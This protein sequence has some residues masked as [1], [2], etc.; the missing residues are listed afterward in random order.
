MKKLFYILCILSGLVFLP[1]T[2]SAQCQKGEM[3]LG[4]A[5]G[6]AS[7][8]KSGYT[9]IYFQYAFSKHVRISPEIGYIFKN[10]GTSGL[11]VSVDMHFP[12][13]VAKAFSIYP[14]AGVTFNNWNYKNNENNYTRCG[15]D[16]GAGAELY[17]TQ[18]LKFSLQGKYSILKNCSG[19]Y[20]NFGVG[21][22][23]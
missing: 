15:G 1:Q 7:F 2:V 5:G 22:I 10:E 13:K 12:F 18:N 4:I 20:V 23:F 21:Y 16:V 3:T 9:D 17:L 6:Y 19:A 14:L 8:N 11:E